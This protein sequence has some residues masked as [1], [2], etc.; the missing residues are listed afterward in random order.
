MGYM[1]PQALEYRYS[2]HDALPGT[3]TFLVEHAGETVGTVTVFPDSPLGLVADEI[4][5]SE[6]DALRAL[7]RHVV[8]VGRL[9]I[10]DD[11]KNQRTILINLF[12]ALELHSRCVRGA[13]DLAITVNPAHVNFY[14][15]MLLFQNIGE[16]REYESVCGAPAVLLRLD[17][18]WQRQ[19]MRWEQ[20]EGPVPVTKPNGRTYYRWF[21]KM[22]EEE[23]RVNRMRKAVHPLSEKFIRRY[24]FHERPLIPNLPS[25][26]QDYFEQCYP[27]LCSA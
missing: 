8:E 10:R 9:A 5:L 4:Y 1:C 12:D 18:E 16:I 2:V 14:Q 19:V 23:T 7:G 17:L 25:P 11:F 21:S 3:V 26:Q 24:F 20:G 22:A 13:T 15:R 6:L 27:G